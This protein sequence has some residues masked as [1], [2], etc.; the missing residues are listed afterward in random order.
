[1]ADNITSPTQRGQASFQKPKAI[2]WPAPDHDR[3]ET[4]CLGSD[5]PPES[6]HKT[7]SHMPCTVQSGLAVSPS[8]P[9]EESPRDSRIQETQLFH[10]P[11]GELPESSPKQP[12]S[13]SA[14]HV[15]QQTPQAS[16]QTLPTKATHPFEQ[17]Y[18]LD[19][20]PH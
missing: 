11:S 14:E 5:P 12:R 7:S 10:S 20:P 19:I 1:M 8:M 13:L 3:P 4:K 6:T 9:Y 2:P 15:S 17:H 18:S 16:W